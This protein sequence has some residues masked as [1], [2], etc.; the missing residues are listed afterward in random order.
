MDPAANVEL[1]TLCVC[2]ILCVGV[3]VAVCVCV[4]CIPM[5][6]SSLFVHICGLVYHIFVTNNKSK[7]KVPANLMRL[8]NVELATLGKLD[9]KAEI[10]FCVNQ[11]S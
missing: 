10:I 3:C 11:E 1:A 4:C 5:T 8:R 6:L 9:Y 7:A 2:A